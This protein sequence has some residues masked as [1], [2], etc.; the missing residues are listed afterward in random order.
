MGRC[1]SGSPRS[2]IAPG[3]EFPWASFDPSVQQAITEGVEAAKQAIHE[4]EQHLG[5]HVN[6]W[7]IALD[8]GRYGTKYAYRAAWTFFGVGGNLIEDACYPFATV[9]GNGE[10][11]DSAQRYQLHFAPDQL[12]P[13]NAFWSLT[14]YDNESYLVAQRDRPLRARRPQRAHFDR[15]RLADPLNPAPSHPAR[16]RSRTGC[17]PPAR[18]ASS[19][20]CGCTLPSP[21]SPTAAGS[22]PRSS[23]SPA[24]ATPDQRVPTA[25]RPRGIPVGEARPRP[26]RHG[27]PAEDGRRRRPPAGPALKFVEKS[28]PAMIRVGALGGWSDWKSHRLGALKLI[29]RPVAGGVPEAPTGRANV[30]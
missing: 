14:M 2:G 5:E 23:V 8:M 10:P 21:R 6:G 19:W 15:R 18:A 29:C 28:L 26:R 16:Q 12:P 24:K 9:D 17:P 30:T 27:L 11:L 4:Q 20:P 1:W 3:A 22:H 25:S 7:Q 13:V